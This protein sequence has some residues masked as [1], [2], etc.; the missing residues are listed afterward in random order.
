[1]SPDGSPDNASPEQIEEESKV[2]TV[3]AISLFEKHSDP[4]SKNL[5]ACDL[6]CQEDPLNEL[7]LVDDGFFEQFKM[8]SPPK[9]TIVTT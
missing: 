1:M 8:S 9:L 2:N 4:G 7:D 3:N 5:E 6:A